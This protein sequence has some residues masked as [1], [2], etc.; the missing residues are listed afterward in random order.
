MKAKLKVS[1]HRVLNNDKGF[2]LIFRTPFGEELSSF[3]NKDTNFD[4]VKAKYPIG[5]IDLFDVIPYQSKGSLGLSVVAPLI[6]ISDMEE[7]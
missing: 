4:L 5:M 3:F 1:E 6:E 2:L 7:F